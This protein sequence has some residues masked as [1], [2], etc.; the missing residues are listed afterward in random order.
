MQPSETENTL[1]VQ[2]SLCL[3]M[4]LVFKLIKLVLPSLH[5]FR[6]LKGENLSFQRKLPQK[7][8]L[9][10]EREIKLGHLHMRIFRI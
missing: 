1:K 8:L 3:E 5:F 4:K 2:Y 6:V 10:R 7:T 9:P